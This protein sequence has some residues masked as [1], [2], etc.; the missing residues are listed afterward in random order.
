MLTPPNLNNKKDKRDPY[1]YISHAKLK[2]V[3]T[4]L[5]GCTSSEPLQGR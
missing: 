4:Q 1:L 2:P 5:N 3:L